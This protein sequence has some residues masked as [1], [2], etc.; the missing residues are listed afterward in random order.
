[1]L[2]NTEFDRK[3]R[4]MMESYQEL[5]P[6]GS[7]ERIL[8][9]LDRK[10]GRVV[11]MRRSL[12]AVAAVAASILLILFI[13]NPLPSSRT[14]V[15]FPSGRL[16]ADLIKPGI[17]QKIEQKVEIKDIKKITIVSGRQK[18]PLRVADRTV[19]ADAVSDKSEK[20]EISVTE[21]NTPIAHREISVSNHEISEPKKEV[22]EPRKNVSQRVTVK[23]EV[24]RESSRRILGMMEEG[25]ERVRDFFGGR[26]ITYAL[27]TNYTP[28]VYSKSVNLLS[29]S[30][31][32]QNDLVPASIKEYVQSQS[33]TD[34][35]YSMPLTFGIQGQMELS[36]KISLGTGV[37]YS[38]LVSNYEEITPTSRL[39]VQQSLHYIGI[40]LNIYFNIFENQEV[41]LYVTGG[42][43]LEKG[44]TASYRII[45]KGVKRHEA[46]KV[47]GLQFSMGAGLGAELKLSNDLGL[48]FDPSLAYFFRGKQP[49]SIR[50]AQ[51]L[52]YK[53]ELGMRFNL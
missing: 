30:L 27:S 49:E 41:K 1:M 52:Q 39:D 34:S 6:D 19:V 35:R 37:N 53:F 51:P 43:T 44:L 46:N 8:S 50:T 7:W 32:Y 21:E 22:A 5:P 20:K 13:G 29:V 12:Y 33:S 10:R 3:I 31:G 17:E 14:T 16:S 11:Y 47:P 24:K 28:S 4:E 40:P 23:E 38:L 26:N 9:S 18:S 48:Y 42:A 2:N 36:D 25:M 45:E 15:D